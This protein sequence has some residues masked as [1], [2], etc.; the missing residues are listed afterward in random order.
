MGARAKRAYGGACRIGVLKMT[1]TRLLT[2]L[3]AVKGRK[4]VSSAT[5]EGLI[6]RGLVERKPFAGP[7]LTLAGRGKLRTLERDEWA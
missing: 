7:V 3:R 4:A 2:A 1:T 6:L 5:L